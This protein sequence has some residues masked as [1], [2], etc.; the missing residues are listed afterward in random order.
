[1]KSPDGSEVL[2][3]QGTS[4]KKYHPYLI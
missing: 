1:V 4:P 2:T 3:V